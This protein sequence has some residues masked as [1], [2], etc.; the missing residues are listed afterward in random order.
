MRVFC[1]LI[2][3]QPLEQGLAS[4]QSISVA[5]MES[6]Y[7]RFRLERAELLDDTGGKLNEYLPIKPIQQIL[8]EQITS[9]K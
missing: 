5:A 8:C 2:G 9:K 3:V 7:E 6:I 4:V 1:I